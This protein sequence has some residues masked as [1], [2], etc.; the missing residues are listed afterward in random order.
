MNVYKFAHLADLHVG[1]NRHPTLQRIEFQLFNEAIGKCLKENVDFILICGDLFHIG[2]PDMGAVKNCVQSLK[3]VYDCGIPVYVIFGSHD[4][5]PNTDSMVD[6]LNSAGLI[7]NIVSGEDIGGKIQLSFYIDPKTGAKITGINAKKG[8]IERIFY[9]RLD[10]VKL[11]NEDGFKIFC[12]HIGLTEL[13]PPH[14]AAM[15]TIPVSL[16]PKGFD[17]YAGGHIHQRIEQK[18]PNYNRIVYPGPIFCGYPRDLEQT[19]RGEQRGLYIVSFDNKVRDVK[20]VELRPCEMNFYEFDV[21]DR[22]AT[23]ANLEIVNYI[24]R[25]NVDQKIVLVKIKGELAGGKPST[26]KTTNLKRMLLENGAIFVDI[27]RYG[28]TSKEFSAV[29]VSGE[30][31]PSIEKILLRQN[32]EAIRVNLKAL[33]GENG[34]ELARRLLTT[35]RTEI[36]ESESRQDYSSRLLESGINTLGIKEAFK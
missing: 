17:Y 15:E 22:N 23:R 1:A 21:T 14:M 26:I 2:I 24:K 30:D 7:T 32:I 3:K 35:L 31:V 10:R 8:G 29:R 9:E 11:E 27:N 13:K 36:K 16:L 5:N 4:Y 20:F 18:L 6:V 12:L 19:A 33:R 34:A 25:L 28:L